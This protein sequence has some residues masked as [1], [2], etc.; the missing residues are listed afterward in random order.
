MSVA[1]PGDGQLPAAHAPGVD[2]DKIGTGIVADA[3]G[4]HG[5]RRRTQI[6]QLDAGKP[7][8]YGAARHMQAALGDAV[9]VLAQSPE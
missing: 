4:P 1:N 9:A 3:T 7:D 6:L 2:M 5:Q 8:V